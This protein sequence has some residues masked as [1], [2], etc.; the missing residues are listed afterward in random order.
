MET[1]INKVAEMIAASKR[2]VVFTGAGISTESGIPDFR[3]PDGLWTKVDPE[4]FTID[5]FLNSGET[6]KKVWYLFV[7]GGS[8]L[9]AEPN[10]AH[11]AIAELEK[12]NKLSSVITQ[13]IDNLHQ[14]AGNHPKKVH[15]LHGNMQ[16]LVCLDCGE[17]YS[18]ELMRQKHPSPD[19]FPVCEKCQ[20]ILKPDVVFFGEMLPQHTLMTAERESRE[21]DLFIVIGSSLV[22]YPAAYMPMYAKRSGAKIVIINMGDTGHDDIADVFIDA[23]AGETM[24]RIMERLRL[25]INS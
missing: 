3:G 16:W 25:I 9:N 19:Y 13:N 8:L 18:V 2:L 1:K 14:K 7:E 6:R 12:M 22:V 20:G 23:P 21:C 11:L 4:D 15:E 17:R 10:R 5:R 24:T